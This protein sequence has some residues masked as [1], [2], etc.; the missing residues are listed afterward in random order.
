MN[1]ASIANMSYITA[2]HDFHIFI[3]H[4]PSEVETDV[5]DTSFSPSTYEI[6]KSCFIRIYKNTTNTAT[7]SLCVAINVHCSHT[8]HERRVTF[9][10]VSI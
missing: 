1:S 8:I 7:C 6:K 9:C 10:S 3:H 4:F 2:D 5:L